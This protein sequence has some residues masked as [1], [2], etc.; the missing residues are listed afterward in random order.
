M[1]NIPNN[2]LR[3]FGQ[4]LSDLPSAKKILN[5]SNAE[6]KK[7]QFYINESNDINILIEINKQH[8]AIF[9]VFKNNRNNINTNTNE[10]GIVGFN[11]YG[12]TN[13]TFEF[14]QIINKIIEDIKRY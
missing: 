13:N 14:D 2:S 12:T 5:E 4:C 8:Y 11:R 3:Y 7:Y 10:I 9:K 1:K 6:Y